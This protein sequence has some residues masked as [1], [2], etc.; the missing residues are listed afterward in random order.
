[1]L[2]AGGSQFTASVDWVTVTVVYNLPGVA[3]AIDLAG[4]GF[5]VPAT[6][7]GVSV[8]LQ[9][10][11]YA[12]NSSMRLCF[13]AFNGATAIGSTNCT[14]AGAAPA[15]LNFQTSAATALSIADANNLSVRVTALGGTVPGTVYLDYAVAQVRYTSGGTT[16]VAECNVHNNWSVAKTNPPI[17]CPATSVTTYFDFT[18][19]RVFDG[20][21]PAGTH[22]RWRLF[23]WDSATPNA[24]KIE[25]RFRSFAP[26]IVGGVSTCVALPGAF[27]DPPASLSVA[28]S[29]PVDTQVCSLTNAP[30]ATCPANLTNYLGNLPN[31][32][33][34]CLQ[35][36]A[37]GYAD[38]L[39]A[40]VLNSGTT[41]YD[42]LPTE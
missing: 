33:L 2:G 1:V 25:F 8:T 30:T 14:T 39:G 12:T 22:T 5:A 37:H 6:A 9:A 16:G 23:G 36:D 18:T 35:M 3:S 28:Q 27:A 13:Q 29:T 21:C 17:Y 41:T 20:V 24:T 34:E 19:T 31:S 7:S 40:P 32:D 26:T 4:Y 38:A 10:R 15:A 42:C 11:W